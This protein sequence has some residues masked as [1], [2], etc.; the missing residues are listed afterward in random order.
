[1]AYLHYYIGINPNALGSRI[2]SA[3]TTEGGRDGGGRPTLRLTDRLIL[4]KVKPN[5][6]T[7]QAFCLKCVIINKR[8]LNTSFLIHQAMQNRQERAKEAARRH[9]RPHGAMPQRVRQPRQA[10]AAAGSRIA[11]R[12]DTERNPSLKNSGSN[13]KTGEQATYGAGAGG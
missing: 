11:R 2:D 5:I 9:P 6:C 10:S 4:C 13:R 3:A 12:Q 8:L 7:R 1:M